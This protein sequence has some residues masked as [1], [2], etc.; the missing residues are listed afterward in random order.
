MAI[1]KPTFISRQKTFGY[2]VI[3]HICGD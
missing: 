2:P 3:L 1:L